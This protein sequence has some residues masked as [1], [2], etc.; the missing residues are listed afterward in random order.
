M[1]PSRQIL[2]ETHTLGALDPHNLAIELAVTTEAGLAASLGH[3]TDNQP[4]QILAHELCHWIDLVGSVW[5]QDYLDS[6]FAALDQAAAPNTD[7]LESYPTMLHLFDRD[8]SIL[9]PSYYK[10]FNPAAH[11]TSD[12]YPWA[13]SGSSGLWITPSGT[14]DQS[15]PI[16]FVQFSEDIDGA[17]VARQ[18]MTVGALLELRAT[19]AEIVTFAHWLAEQSADEQIVARRLFRR[20][21]IA[22]FYDPSFTTYSVAAHLLSVK[23]GN[24]DFVTTCLNGAILADLCLNVVPEAFQRLQHPKEFREFP[25]QRL[26]AFKLIQDRGYLFACLA[27]FA[28][29]SGTTSLDAGTIAALVAQIGLGSPDDIYNAAEHLFEQRLASVSPLRDADLSRIR[30]EL[31]RM[32]LRILRWRRQQFAG[33]VPVRSYIAAGMPSPIVIASD[34]HE[35]HITPDSIHLA[36]SDLLGRLGIRVRELTRSALR[37]GRGLDFGFSDYVY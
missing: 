35:L 34:C 33:I 5:G 8:R 20:T 16:L 26:D 18:P 24:Q 23:T 19:A 1:L 25:P 9:F 6:V 13:L 28:Q 31:T 4:V 30:M 11:T 15:R 21:R 17:L 29:E 37:A 3:G 14:L 2:P 22:T 10:I 36:D 32:G 12:R 27:I 7:G